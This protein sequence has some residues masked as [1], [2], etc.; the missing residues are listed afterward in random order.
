MGVVSPHGGQAVV[1]AFVSIVSCAA[2]LL[3]LKYFLVVADW[4]VLLHRDKKSSGRA[5]S[6]G[7]SSGRRS[8]VEGP[9]LAIHPSFHDSVLSKTTQA[10]LLYSLW[11][12]E[13]C[14]R[15]LSGNFTALDG[16]EHLPDAARNEVLAEAWRS[17][18]KART[19]KGPEVYRGIA[20]TTSGG[21]IMSMP[22]AS[23]SMKRGL[24]ITSATAEDVLPMPEQTAPTGITD[25]RMQEDIVSSSH[26]P[27]IGT[28]VADE[29]SYDSIFGMVPPNSVEQPLSMCACLF[30]HFCA[31]LL[32]TAGVM[33]TLARE[34]QTR[35]GGVCNRGASAQS[36]SVQGRRRSSPV[37]REQSSGRP[38]VAPAPRPRGPL[39]RR[40]EVDESV[41]PAPPASGGGSSHMGGSQQ[42][43]FGKLSKRI[44]VVPPMPIMSASNDHLFPQLRRLPS[45]YNC[46]DD[47][48]GSIIVDGG[49][50]PDRNCYISTDE[51]EQEI[52]P[53]TSGSAPHLHHYDP[54]HSLP[55]TSDGGRSGGGVPA[56]TTSAPS[57]PLRA[58]SSL[59]DLTTGTILPTVASKVLPVVTAF[60]VYAVL[61]L[62]DLPLVPT[63]EQSFLSRFRAEHFD[64]HADFS[65]FRIVVEVLVQYA[66]PL[67][68]AGFHLLEA[69]RW[70]KI[71]VG[72]VTDV[73]DFWDHDHLRATTRVG[74]S[75]SS[76]LLTI[77]CVGVL[78]AKVIFLWR[79]FFLPWGELARSLA[80]ELCEL[81]CY[82]A[83]FGYCMVGG[84][85][86][87]VSSSAVSRGVVAGDGAVV[88]TT[89]SCWLKHSASL[90]LMAALLGAAVRRAVDSENEALRVIEIGFL[91]C[92]VAHRWTGEPSDWGGE[93]GGEAAKL[94][95]LHCSSR[96]GAA[97]RSGGQSQAVEIEMSSL[98]Q[99]R[100]DD[101]IAGKN[102]GASERAFPSRRWSRGAGGG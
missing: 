98:L 64:Q 102:E 77:F 34:R 40:T 24:G 43:P 70:G 78:L 60:V 37:D 33:I 19:H 90:C 17:G 80:A 8:T 47:S 91:L 61:A 9:W 1:F 101:C 67:L 26:R 30:V 99:R 25:N 12:E 55:G 97:Q 93:E 79:S 46:R 66:L 73:V 27:G 48:A 15:T 51:F 68:A 53:T 11:S 20:A 39:L 50:P 22:S 74:P 71:R 23:S 83:I 36:S 13:Q 75:L 42:R 57:L 44:S 88:P 7:N 59:L 45:H 5:S 31:A 38:V 49:A 32:V 94:P 6:S 18:T 72:R 29:R 4:A 86:S 63:R 81:V 65:V 54:H 58:A 76:A 100:R 85:W 82:H 16:D 2:A 3:A 95:P 92:C 87:G 56:T 84:S 28:L 69:S 41:S 52:L 62:A 10:L 89:F 21:G 14:L 96:E 35:G